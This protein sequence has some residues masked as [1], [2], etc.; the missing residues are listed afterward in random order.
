MSVH[1]SGFCQCS[2]IIVLSKINF[3]LYS[4]VVFIPILL[5]TGTVCF[6]IICLHVDGNMGLHNYICNVVIIVPHT[7][8]FYNFNPLCWVCSWTILATIV[9]TVK[10][11]YFSIHSYI[12]IHMFVCSFSL[13]TLILLLLCLYA[14]TWLCNPFWWLMCPESFSSVL[15]LW[16]T[17]ILCLWSLQSMWLCLWLW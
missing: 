17:I 16:A 12:C 11:E 5:L 8:S 2:I 13:S 6:C 10:I 9:Y 4:K 1:Q 15:A 14:C 7:L 3:I